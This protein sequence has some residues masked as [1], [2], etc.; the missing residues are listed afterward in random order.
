M[1][2]SVILPLLTVKAMIVVTFPC[3]ATTAP[4]APLTRAEAPLAPHDDGA[5]HLGRG[6]V[7]GHQPPRTEPR[8]G[9]PR[10]SDDVPLPLPA[11]PACRHV[12]APAAAEGRLRGPTTS[13]GARSSSRGTRGQGARRLGHPGSPPRQ[14][15]PDSFR[16]GGPQT[17][18]S[19]PRMTAS[20][21]SQLQPS[22][23]TRPTIRP[24]SASTRDPTGTRAASASDNS[25]PGPLP[26]WVLAS[27][28]RI[29]GTEITDSRQPRFPHRHWLSAPGS[30]VCPISP[31]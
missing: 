23:I 14:R 11:R 18:S 9:G 3:A 6:A 5:G 28:L 25:L 12:P 7:A 31:A 27:C 13:A 8:P 24:A 17:P 4:A 22:A 10:P 20:G 1:S 2:I 15:L 29:S 30:C 16:E 21:L 19:P 26:K